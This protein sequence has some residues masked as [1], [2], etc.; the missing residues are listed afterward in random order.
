VQSEPVRVTDKF[1]L[2]TLAIALIC[3]AYIA[4]LFTLPTFPTQDGPVHDEYTHVLSALLSSHPGHFATFYTIKHY[5]PPYSLYYYTLL[6]LT[7]IFPVFTADKIIVSAYI[8]TFVFGFRYLARA[9][10]P[11]YNQATL[12][13]TL[14]LLNWPLGMGFVN[15]CFSLAIS[16]WAYGLW[17]RNTGRN[18]LP[19]KALF[20]LLVVIILLT[21]P[22]PL[23][24]LVGFCALDLILRRLKPSATFAPALP[25]DYLTFLL[26]LFAVA[27]IKLFTN[28]HPLVQEAAQNAAQN[29]SQ[30]ASN[31]YRSQLLLHLR[32]FPKG[33]GLSFFSFGHHDLLL[34]RALLLAIVPLALALA[35]LQLRRNRTLGVRSWSNRWFAIAFATLVLLPFMPSDLNAS[36]FFAE[37]LLIFV[38]L[39]ILLAASGYVL[40]SRAAKSAILLYALLGTAVILENAHHYLRPE[41][42]FAASFQ[43][44][45]PALRG[46]PGLLLAGPAQPAYPTGL[47]FNPREWDAVHF[48]RFNDAILLDGPWLHLA[49]IPI[50]AT[51]ALSNSTLSQDTLDTPGGVDLYLH[52]TP[53][54]IP[55]VLAPAAFLFLDQ[56]NPAI[57]A[58]HPVPLPF[59]LNPSPNPPASW[60]LLQSVPQRYKI[61]QR[62]PLPS[63]PPAP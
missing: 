4:F 60:F 31:S 24:A 19:R 8:L 42:L 10:G 21:H 6:L 28:A 39:T 47:A 26:S 52:S 48:F 36:H 34:Y 51:S 50:G 32:Q 54:D 59:A 44:S 15:F 9:I 16:F 63:P 30:A 7:K 11:S 23:L 46:R 55:A 27:Y 56:T 49:V 18:S 2:E 40:R 13:V 61:Y 33:A 53:A 17:I 14:C 1:P 12:I 43:T 38:W 25:Q 62:S 58:A 57:P 3:A 41:A 45:V 22:V 37:R 20:L 35:Y 29:T 5:L